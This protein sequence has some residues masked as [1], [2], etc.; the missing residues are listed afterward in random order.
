MSLCLSQLQLIVQP[1]LSLCD[2]ESNARQWTAVMWLSCPLTSALMASS[3]TAVT[4][5][6]L[7]VS[8]WPREGVFSSLIVLYNLH[9]V[10][11]LPQFQTFSLN[12][13][14]SLP[15]IQTFSLNSLHSLPQIQTFSLNSLHSLP[16]IQTFSLNSLHS[17]PQF[18]TFSLNS[19]HSLRFMPYLAPN[20]GI[21]CL[22]RS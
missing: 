18:Q 22:S 17:L 9:C 13:L 12:S 5:T 10:P 2:K 1:P 15:Q 14:H 19:L 6:S 20:Y 3:P 11:P 21:F 7:L 8:N 4:A 16:Q